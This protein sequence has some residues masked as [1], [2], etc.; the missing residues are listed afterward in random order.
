MHALSTISFSRLVSQGRRPGAHLYMRPSPRR[1][2][3]AFTRRQRSLRVQADSGTPSSDPE[4]VRV[5]SASSTNTILKE[6]EYVPP[7][8]EPTLAGKIFGSYLQLGVWIVV[9]SFAGYKGIQQVH[10]TLSQSVRSHAMM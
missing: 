3:F 9:L 6:S 8:D 2:R 5:F 4:K 7:D 1:S 10:L